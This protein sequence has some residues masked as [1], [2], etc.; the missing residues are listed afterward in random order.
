M[1]IADRR[2]APLLVL[3]LVLCAF[4]PA[5]AIAQRVLFD[6]SHGQTAGAAEWIVDS[7][8]S[9]L[10]WLNF[11]CQP[12]NDRHPSGQRFPTP[13]QE[14]LTP[15][16]DETAWTG[17][18]S[19]WAM[20]LAMDALDPAWDRDWTI[21]QYPW[22]A[23]PFTFGDPGN[24]QDLSSYDV[25]ILCEPNVLFTDAE[26][27]AIRE[28]VANGGGLFLCAD[29]ETSD[30]NCSGGADEVHDSPFI[31]NRM[32]QTDVET[33]TEPPYFDPENPNNDF[34]VFGI[35]FYEN[36]NDSEG[37]SANRAFD[38]FT[39]SASRNVEDDPADPILHGPFGDGTGGIGLFGATQMAVSTHPERG[40]PTARAHIWRNDASREPGSQGVF[41]RVTFASA[42]LGA[43]RVVAV[44]DS[45]P[46][47]DGSGKKPLHDGWDQAEGGVANDV[48]FL[49]ATEWIANPRPD[50]TAPKITAGPA[51]IASD[52][53]ALVTWV[54]DEPASSRVFFG[55][56]T[57]PSDTTQAAGLHTGHHV[58][59]NGLDPSTTYRYSVESIDRSGN[60]VE[61]DLE[62]FTTI[63]QTPVGLGAPTVDAVT[64]DSVT[65]S[66]S[67]A[68]EA[69]GT[70][71]A[72]AGGADTRAEAPESLASQTVTVTGLDPE[73]E[74]DL[75]VEAMDACGSLE[76]AVVS[77]I[78]AAA[79]AT[80]D[81]SGWKL[82][83]DHPQF[84][85]TFP[86]GTEVPA[87]G[88]LVVGRA[89]DRAGF[90]SEWGPLPDGVVY[91]DSGDS[92]I[93]NA[94]PRPYT[95]L[96]DR[97]E[98]VDGP[99]V[100][101]AKGSSKARTDACADAGAATAWS[102]RSQAQ[103]DPGRGAPPACGAGVVI[104]EMS[105]AGD[106]RNEFV[107]IRFDP[108]N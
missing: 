59:L 74:Y 31:L 36:G 55:E 77:A 83:N 104:T 98:P 11:R 37:D 103:A 71:M 65:I 99:T 57:P 13:A 52:C 62:T 84:E 39:E 63:G 44:G 2:V 88:F 7:D 93:V 80:F 43:G 79:P 105:D 94:T 6:A 26:S 82:V 91:V 67:T 27:Q 96:D 58:V 68:K 42:E 85:L 35:W 24:P 22:D 28:F 95:L 33:R 18:L 21:E 15:G 73:T 60:P 16:A 3:A 66:W 89:N 72:S 78:T 49:N 4:R 8:S 5:P 9:E 97:G 14:T 107:E 53:T 100:P 102:S 87:G 25:L 54:T 69:I 108:P 47:D 17:G 45:S 10:R 86:E 106:F 30:R 64:H 61:S 81:L 46:A 41:T 48:V 56:S 75:T 29:H 92:L 32:M 23:P 70:L 34:G 50:T 19:A 101:I 1:P 51:A 12:T 38:W 90:E 20:D 40:N 76:T